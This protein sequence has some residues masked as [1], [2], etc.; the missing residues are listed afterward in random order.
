MAFRSFFS[1]CICILALGISMSSQAGTYTVGVEQVEYYPLW[2][3]KD[4]DYVGYGR[5]VLD[6][7]AKDAG[8]T[9]EYKPMPIKRLYGT[10]FNG[11]VDLKFP[12]NP[13]WSK[14][15]R[16]GKTFHYSD[17]VTSYVDGVMVLPAN[18]NKG[19]EALNKLG[20]L[21]GFTPWDYLDLIE[22]GKVKIYEQNSLDSLV[23]MAAAG[24]VDGIYFNVDVSQHYLA[25]SGFNQSD[26]VWDP[27]LPH[28]K[29]E[30][31]MSTMKHPAIIEEFNAWMS[32]NQDLIKSL[33][34]KYNLNF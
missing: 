34:E 4:G 8:H 19:V 29:A 17:S 13:Y 23:M 2:A 22:S 26:L 11:N 20:T 16:K 12:D 28:T 9:L 5:E 7:F 30:Y 14:D 31:M 32:K 33:K 6:A 21:R 1:S 24:R 3:V 18:K 27:D 25:N 15:Q 10:F